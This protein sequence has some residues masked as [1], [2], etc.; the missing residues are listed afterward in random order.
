MARAA[1]SVL[2]RLEARGSA[3]AVRAAA[4][5]AVAASS[6]ATSAVEAAIVSAKRGPARR[7]S[8]RTA[9]EV[10]ERRHRTAATGNDLLRVGNVAATFSAR[11]RPGDDPQRSPRRAARQS[12]K[13]LDRGRGNLGTGGS[14]RARSVAAARPRRSRWMAATLRH[15]PRP[16]ERIEEAR[17]ITIDHGPVIVL[18]VDFDE[19][20]AELASSETE[21]AGR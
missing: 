3:S 5:R 7:P 19:R 17:W 18:A 1:K 11:I 8:A 9:D 10:G 14:I 20:G 16:A 12:P 13:F 2:G 21:P 15:P 4:S 6:S